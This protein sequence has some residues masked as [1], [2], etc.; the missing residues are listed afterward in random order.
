MS[1]A[2]EVDGT[3]AS[4]KREFRHNPPTWKRSSSKERNAEGTT[5]QDMPDHN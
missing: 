5:S 4:Q 2:N 3:N 1:D